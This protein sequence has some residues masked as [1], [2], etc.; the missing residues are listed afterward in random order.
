MPKKHGVKTAY[1][2]IPV[3]SDFKQAVRQYAAD[4]S[5]KTGKPAPLSAVV[6]AAAFK[7][8]PQL[9]RYYAAIRKGGDG[10]RINIQ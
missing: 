2:Q 1:D 9:R 5:E 10:N 4:L 3:T 7:G 8:A 6:Q